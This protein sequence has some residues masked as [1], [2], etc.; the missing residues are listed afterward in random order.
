[1][2]TIFRTLEADYER[3]QEP[4]I[5]CPYCGKKQENA[6]FGDDPSY[7]TCEHCDEEFDVVCD[8]QTVY[9]SYK[10]PCDEGCCTANNIR[11][12]TYKH[13]DSDSY[14]IWVSKC[15]ECDMKQLN[16]TEW[17][18]ACMIPI[19]TKAVHMEQV[20]RNKSNGLITVTKDARTIQDVIGDFENYELIGIMG[21]SHAYNSEGVLES[22]A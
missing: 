5:K 12:N 4:Y 10:K 14:V 17:G 6:L 19:T 2:N 18:N 13:S 22:L 16:K 7:V 20:W 21:K 3:W 1:M 15:D 11:L 8:I 9:S